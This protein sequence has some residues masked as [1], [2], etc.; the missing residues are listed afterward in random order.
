MTRTPLSV[1]V[2]VLVLLAAATA[3]AAPRWRTLDTTVDSGEICLVVEDRELAYT[4]LDAEEPAVIRLRGPRRMKILARGLARPGGDPG[5]FGFI[6]C[7]E[8][9][10]DEVLN[11]SF[12]GR[13]RGDVGVCGDDSTRVGGLNRAYVDVPSGWHELEVTA[14]G[15]AAARFFRETRRKREELVT[16]APE[17]Y[18][19]VTHLQFDSGSRSTY[20]AFTPRQPLV[21]EVTGPTTLTV[22]TRLDFDHTMSGSQPY[23]LEILVDGEPRRTVHYDAEKLAAAVYT[24]RPGILPGERKSLTLP[25]GKGRHRVEIRCVRPESCCVAAKIR[26]PAKD[27][28]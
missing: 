7:V 25:L 13:T 14:V 3:D 2:I 10:G 24:D 5:R 23:A 16:Y 19:D 28:R 4:R 26:I 8:L 20:Y 6:L 22:W 1:S 12:A 27:V 18:A 9:D 15:D 21:C 17:R 11:E